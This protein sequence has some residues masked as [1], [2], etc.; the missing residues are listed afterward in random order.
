MKVTILPVD[1]SG[2]P[3]LQLKVTDPQDEAV[4]NAILNRNGAAVKPDAG[5]TVVDFER[6]GDS[7]NS[8]TFGRNEDGLS[9]GVSLFT[10]TADG[11]QSYQDDSLIDK[12]IVAV[13]T[14]S[15]VRVPSDYSFDDTTGTLTFTANVDV[16]TI[17]QLII[18]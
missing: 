16:N 17:I 5:F 9:G 2:V 10:I 14:D 6:N 11:G 13:F 18:R 15:V 4:L 1:D 3:R 8:V 12:T 7:F